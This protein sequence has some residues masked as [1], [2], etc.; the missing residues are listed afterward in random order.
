VEWSGGPI[1]LI[2]DSLD[3]CGSEADRK[4]LI[5]ALVKG[6]SDLPSFIRI[7]VVS[8]QELDIQHTLG[9][10]SH[11][12]PYPLDI[13]AATNKGDISEFGRHRLDEIRMK[14][15]FLDAHW[16]GD[17]KIS[18][19]T[20]SAGG[21][22]IWASTA[23]LSIKS[24]DPDQRLPELIEKLSDS[25][26]SGR[27]AQ[28]DTLYKTGLQSAGLWNDPS[29]RSGCRSILGVILCA[30]I[31]LSDSVINSI[32]SLP[33]HRPCH[34]SISCLGVLFFTLRF[35]PIFQDDALG[36]IGPSISSCIT[37]NSLF[38]AS[39]FWTRNCRRISA[40]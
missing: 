20:K 15:G 13:D 37:R 7:M 40:T 9:S 8:R 4:I 34:K 38:I 16:P 3:E 24:Y 11:V 28:L 32:L 1:L 27:F 10:H 5:Q 19:L 6:F 14:D 30:R 25:H 39:N 18:A 36:S 12:R 33:Q 29:F 17:N 35:R 31:P 23:C 22:F 21:L 2:I 26:S